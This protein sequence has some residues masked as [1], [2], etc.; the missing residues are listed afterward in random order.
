MTAARSDPAAGL[1]RDCLADVPAGARRCPSCRR[2]RVLFHPRLGDLSIAHIDCDAFFAAVEKRDNPALA[3]KPV[4]IGGGRRGVVSTACYIARISGVRSAMPMFK[5]LKACPNAV[6]I[7]PDMARY[8]AA[9]RDIRTRMEALTPLIEPLSLDEAFLDLTGTERLHG[10]VPARLLARLAL[11]IERD[12][13]ITVSVGLSGNKFLAKLASEFDKPRG[14]FV[15]DPQEAPEILKDRPVTAIF[16]VGKAFAAALARDGIT[17]IRHLQNAQEEDLWRRH[18]SMGRRLWWLARGIDERPVR[19]DRAVKS[20][21]GETTFDTD[22]EATD[23]LRARLW[24][25]CEKVSMRS[26]IKGL[27]GRVVTLKLKTAAFATRTR[28]TTLLRPTQM[29]H[30]LFEAAAPLLERE[31]DGTRFR[32][33]GV[34]LSDLVPADRGDGPDLL[35]PQRVRRDEAERA[36]DTVRSK[37]GQDVITTGRGLNGRRR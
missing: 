21:S 11:E 26:K 18:G 32:L 12:V 20:I 7:K 33:I 1:C 2:G 9:A 15:L 13:G 29:A 14:F 24:P 17:H 31:A 34:G 28:R 4:I 36:M 22:V 5:A 27:A 37:F 25:L 10:G 35:E 8:A 30:T 6:V 3:D 23:A 16:G 19:P